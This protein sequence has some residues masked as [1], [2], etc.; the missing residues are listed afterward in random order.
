MKKFIDEKSCKPF[1]RQAKTLLLNAL[2]RGFF[3]RS[4]IEYM[5]IYGFFA[6]SDNNEHDYRFEDVDEELLDRFNKIA[7]EYE[8]LLAEVTMQMMNG[9]SERLNE[10]KN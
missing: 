5:S 2:K 9:L 4:D 7:A 6:E 10:H 1:K 3:M 8:E